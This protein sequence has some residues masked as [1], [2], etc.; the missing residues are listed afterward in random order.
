MCL[1]GQVLSEHQTGARSQ[2]LEGVPL[3]VP[4]AVTLMGLETTVLSEV[5][6]TGTSII[7]YCLYV[8]PHK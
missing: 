3:P 7:E 2:A 6:Q 5:S 4:F 1:L 8:E